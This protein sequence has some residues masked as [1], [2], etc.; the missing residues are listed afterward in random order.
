M[1]HGCC[2]GEGALVTERGERE[3]ERERERDRER[4]T[5]RITR[6]YFPKA[7]DWKNERVQF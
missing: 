2:G 4:S 1:D 5:H 7:I 6:E 3:K